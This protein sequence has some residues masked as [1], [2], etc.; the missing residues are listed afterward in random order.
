MR[1]DADGHDAEVVGVAPDALFTGFHRNNIRP[2][3]V[4]LS[5]AQQ[6]LEPGDMTFC[7][8]YAGSLDT[9]APAVSRSLREVDAR[10]PIVHLRTMETQLKSINWP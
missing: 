8:R 5:A 2:K 6:P 1:L 7:L 4:F 9:I 3:F 10:A